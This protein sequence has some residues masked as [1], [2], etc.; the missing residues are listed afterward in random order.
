LLKIDADGLVPATLGD[1]DQL[2]VGDVVLAIGDPFGIGQSVSRGIVSALGRSNLGIEAVEDFIQTDAAI[3]PGNSGGALIDSA[4]RVIGLNTAIAAGEHGGAGVG[5]AI[6]INLARRIA[7]QIVTHGRIERGYLGIEPQSLTPELAE[8]FKADRGALVTQVAPDGPAARAGLAPGDVITKVNDK[9]VADEGH[10][11]LTISSLAPGSQATIEYV[12]DGKT[13]TA[14]AT[15]DRRPEEKIAKA[16]PKEPEVLSPTGRV[17]EPD[18]LSGVAVD[19]LTPELRSE[20]KIPADVKGAVITQ[21]DP[22]SPSAR[23]GLQPG[24][25]ILELNRQPVANAK[26]AVDFSQQL[27]D[28]K[29]LARIWREGQ[30]RFIVIKQSAG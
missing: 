15:L 17:K 7:D 21:I 14:R 11:L 20:L 10:L 6:P 12:R 9:P 5:F 29:V 3:N 27:K 28:T 25:V 8:E 22:A 2:Q 26:Q 30:T 13:R 23:E 16:T 19:D 24:D 1:S 18:V 4:G